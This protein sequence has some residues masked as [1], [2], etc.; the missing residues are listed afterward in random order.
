[1]LNHSAMGAI[2]IIVG[3]RH[4]SSSWMLRPSGYWSLWRRHVPPNRNSGSSSRRSQRSWH[5]GIGYRFYHV[6]SFIPFHSPEISIYELRWITK[7]I[8]IDQK[9]MEQCFQ[10]GTHDICTY[11]P[12]ISRCP[13]FWF[14]GCKKYTDHHT[15]GTCMGRDTSRFGRV[16]SSLVS[17]RAKGYIY[18]YIIYIIYIYYN[19]YNVINQG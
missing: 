16:G 19:W 1:M 6:L 7:M 3:R 12:Y 9:K 8:V 14:W 11:V 5:H 17:I 2:K 18:M 4:K 10:G 15:P 13:T